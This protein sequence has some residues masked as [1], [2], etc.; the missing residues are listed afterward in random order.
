MVAGA[1]EGLELYVCDTDK[2]WRPY[3]LEQCEYLF[4]TPEIPNSLSNGGLI[5][6]ELSCH[7]LAMHTVEGCQF[8]SCCCFQRP[9]FHIVLHLVRF[10]R[11]V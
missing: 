2:G 3:I 11:R 7:S 10:Q 8:L 6:F 5:V 4:N 9:G 1:S